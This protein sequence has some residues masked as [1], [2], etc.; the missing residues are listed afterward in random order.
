VSIV[1][2]A[3]CLVE[4]INRATTANDNRRCFAI[5]VIINIET[6]CQYKLALNFDLK[7]KHKSIQGIS[8]RR[9]GSLFLG[10]DYK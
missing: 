7:Q 3:S 9:M 2:C 1:H 4:E 5:R 10:L 6:Q 8:Q